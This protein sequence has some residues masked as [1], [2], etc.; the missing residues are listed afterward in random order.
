[1]TQQPSLKVQRTAQK[2]AKQLQQ[3]ERAAKAN[4]KRQHD[5]NDLSQWQ[6]A[7]RKARLA[8]LMGNSSEISEECANSVYKNDYEA[9]EN[10]VYKRNLPE[11]LTVLEMTIR[12]G[13]I[14][15]AL[16]ADFSSKC[17]QYLLDYANSAA[18]LIAQPL[19]GDSPN[20]R[21]AELADLYELI[22]HMKTWLGALSVNTI[23]DIVAYNAAVQA[24]VH[25][26]GFWKTAPQVQAACLQIIKGDSLTAIAKKM[27]IKQTDL[28]NQVLQAAKHLYR[29]GLAVDDCENIKP[30]QSIPDLRQKSWQWLSDFD[31]VAQFCAKMMWQIIKP[32]SLKTAIDVIGLEKYEIEIV[33]AQ[34]Q[35]LTA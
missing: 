25:F 3:A 7:T 21:R 29:V 24:A 13:K 33:A 20:Q 14:I 16:L 28:K 5:R 18:Q 9:V 27:S 23:G 10:L 19:K 17:S 2:Q 4:Q 15:S 1:M 34:K 11:T 35:I 30:A 22:W 26:L 6:H 31:A 32:F 8:M 12:A